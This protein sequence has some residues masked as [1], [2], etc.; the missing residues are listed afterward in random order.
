M[1]NKTS[2]DLLTRNEAAEI[3]GVTALTVDAYRKNGK[4]PWLRYG[5]TG[6]RLRRADV[7]AVKAAQTTVRSP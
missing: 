7:D 1:T 3:L 6:I 2:P 5:P 4:L